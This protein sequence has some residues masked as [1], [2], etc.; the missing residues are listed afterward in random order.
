MKR[1]HAANLCNIE[2]RRLSGKDCAGLGP[3]LY[4]VAC[5]YYVHRL[6]LISP[7]QFKIGL[8]V[9]RKSPWMIPV[10]SQ[11]YAS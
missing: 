6:F 5:S 9:S 11:T 3:S 10:N 8:N 1:F 7:M 4:T 2:K